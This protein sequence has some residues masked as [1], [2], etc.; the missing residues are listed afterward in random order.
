MTIPATEGQSLNN[1]VVATFTES[2]LGNVTNDFT[3]SIN[4]GDGTAASIGTIQPN[5]GTNGYNIL[6]SHTYAA[7]GTYTV[8]VTLTDLGSTGTTTVAGTTI[9]VT[10][11]GPVN[12]TPNPIV[13]T[14]STAAAPLIAQG[15]P[16][17]GFKGV[18]LNPA[19]GGDVLVATFMDTGT[20]GTPGDYTASINWG[21]GTAATAD[22]RITSQGTANGVVFSVF[23]NH[24]YTM[25][26]SFTVVTT[27]T[28]TA[29][30]S[31]AVASSTAT[32]ALQPPSVN[33]VTNLKGLAVS[34]VQDVQ[35]TQDVATF[36]DTDTSAIPS[37][38]TATINWGDGTTNT[39][40]T[41]TEDASNLFHVTGTHTYTKAGSFTPT[42]TIKDLN[43]TLYATGVFNQ[44]NLVSSVSG[45]A[46]VLDPS[47]I[48]PWGMSSSTTSPIWVSDQ[49]SGV[50]TLYNPNGTPIKQGSPSR[51][52]RLARHL[53]RPGRS[54]TPTP[55]RVTSSSRRQPRRLCSSSPAST[56]PSWRG[57]PT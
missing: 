25:T 21:D 53:A 1:V 49:G 5:G 41:I 26:G 37:D 55:T 14:A 35:T 34:A 52:R 17:S 45:M 38:F 7:A 23:G 46:A 33:S 40:G 3:A 8:D 18:P 29:S 42:V 15:V 50:A 10:S 36:N 31:T 19:P 30:T 13:S 22:T 47:L 9:N 4:W 27:I 54:S 39:A 43:G 28:K 57:T 11:N 2:D 32:I 24:T 44:T 12:S 6:G 48:N 16:V 20:A 56:A 51:S